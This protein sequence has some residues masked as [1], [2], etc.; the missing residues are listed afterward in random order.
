MGDSRE[1]MYIYYIVARSYIVHW[2]ETG[3]SDSSRQLEDWG[4]LRV[5]KGTT[6][7]SRRWHDT[8][9]PLSSD[10]DKSASFA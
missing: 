6:F 1:S 5:P 2:F 4:S 7:S 3:E 9:S 8:Y 10:K